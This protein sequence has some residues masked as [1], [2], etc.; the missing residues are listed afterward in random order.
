M[1]ATGHYR[2]LDAPVDGGDLHL[3]IWEPEG[4]AAGTVLAIHGITASHRAW[5]WLAEELPQWRIIAPDLRGRGRSNRLPGPYGMAAHADDLAGV[6]GE[7]G[8]T[9]PIPVVGHSMGAFVGLVLAHRHPE[10]VSRLVMVDGGIPIQLPPSVGPE[11]V[12][13][14]VLG[15]AAQ[16]LSMTF[17]TVAA[18]QEFWRA[19]PAFHDAWESRLAA[20]AAYDLEGEE[21]ELHPATRYEAMA[22]DSRD[23]QLG[24]ALAAAL[25]GLAH[26]AVF[27]RAERGMQNDAPLFAPE[28]VASWLE[29]L[30]GLTADT[31]P[32]VNHYTIIMSADGVRRVAAALA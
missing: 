24:D 8:M 32:G 26:P 14:S 16:R 13:Q 1:S 22:G 15:P 27:L 7:L 19:L 23:I 2:E 9:G 3:G 20:Y 18:Y 17:P 5:P 28:W 30:P 29:R 25:A 10:L 12:L 31:V 4:E 11:D 6:L 21:P